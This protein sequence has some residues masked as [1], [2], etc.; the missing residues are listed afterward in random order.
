MCCRLS[1]L[2]PVPWQC[3]Q[4]LLAHTVLYIILNWECYKCESAIFQNTG[5][6]FVRTI[7]QIIGRDDDDKKVCLLKER[8][9]KIIGVRVF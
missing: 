4:K 5:P 1:S 8:N 6:F 7:C 2:Q 9:I 3:C